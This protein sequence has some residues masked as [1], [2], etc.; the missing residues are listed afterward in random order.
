MTT[1]REIEEC[2]WQQIAKW[3]SLSMDGTM[4]VLMVY[5]ELRFALYDACVAIRSRSG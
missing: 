5:D 2:Y 1:A 4:A 3:R